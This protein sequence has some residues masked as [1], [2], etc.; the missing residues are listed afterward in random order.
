MIVLSIDPGV[1]KV[2]YAFFEKYNSQNYR[3]IS[4]GLIKTSKTLPHE[5]RLELIYRGLEKL[6]KKEKPDMLVMER[7]FFTNNQKTAISVGQA[8]GVI[9]LLVSIYKL[10]FMYLTPSQIKMIVTGTGNSDKRAVQKMLG[11]ILGLT[12]DLKQ[13]DQADAIACGYAFCCINEALIP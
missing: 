7:L 3:Y 5:N 4:S 12:E 10:S 2:G 8:Q 6:I 13:D 1:E 11:L 9:M